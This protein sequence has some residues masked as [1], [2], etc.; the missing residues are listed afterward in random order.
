M[1]ICVFRD[2]YRRRGLLPGGPYAAILLPF[3]A[4]GVFILIGLWK[5]VANL[6]R[7]TGGK[8]LGLRD[9]HAHRQAVW[10]V[11]R[12]RYLEGGGDGCNFVLGLFLTMPYGK[13]IHAVYRYAALVRNALEAEA[14]RK[15]LRLKAAIPGGRFDSL[16][17]YGIRFNRFLFN[18][19]TSPAGPA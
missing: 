18:R 6:W 14:Q 9:L 2:P 1:T 11:L 13:F 10:D 12:L 4:L 7:E 15:Q 17:S 16:G 5:G 8:P 19:L 3:T